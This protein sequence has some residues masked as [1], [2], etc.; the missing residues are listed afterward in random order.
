M[1]IFPALSK[2]NASS[3]KYMDNEFTLFAKVLRMTAYKKPK[4]AV[5]KKNKRDA[6]K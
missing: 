3:K 4:G 2:A 5:I 1:R 6:K